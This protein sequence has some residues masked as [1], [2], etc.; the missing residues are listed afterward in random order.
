MS[1]TRAAWLCFVGAL[2]A[3]SLVGAWVLTRSPQS[4]TL[5]DANASLGAVRLGPEGSPATGSIS[6]HSSADSTPV[7]REEAGIKSGSRPVL[8]Y[9]SSD[10]DPRSLRASM[11]QLGIDIPVVEPAF[12]PVDPASGLRLPWRQ[13]LIEHDKVRSF[14]TSDFNRDDT[15]DNTDIDAFV[16]EWV[17]RDGP[18][19]ALLD[20]DQDGWITD[21]DFSAFID[22]F[23]EECD[24]GVQIALRQAPQVRLALRI[25]DVLVTAE[26][27][28][29]HS[30]QRAPFLRIV[31]TPNSQQL[32][33]RLDSK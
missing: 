9:G 17:R 32:E 3:T 30:V 27:V 29:I 14:C 8:P 23:D 6:S 12:D 24:P 18:L 15:I 10:T 16:D 5:R 11:A 2:S 7:T 31:V 20:I 1:G 4:P 22:S 33:I 25:E 19:A 21:D 26:H 13:D 28:N